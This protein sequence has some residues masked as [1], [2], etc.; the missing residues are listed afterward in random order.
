MELELN[1][2]L[3]C[4]FKRPNQLEMIYF[5]V[6]IVIFFFPSRLRANKTP[7]RPN[8]AASTH[9]MVVS[10][11]LLFYFFAFFK[12]FSSFGLSSIVHRP[13]SLKNKLHLWR[14]VCACF[15]LSTADWLSETV[16]GLACRLQC[17]KPVQRG[18]RKVNFTCTETVSLVRLKWRRPG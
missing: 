13:L 8:K 12:I 17:C 14:P 2:E 7:S 10:A 6:C 3:V 16:T 9:T 5:P 18:M 15:S 11:F 4:L 1:G